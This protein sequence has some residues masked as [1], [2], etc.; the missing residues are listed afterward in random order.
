MSEHHTHRSHRTGWLRAGGFHALYGAK[1]AVADRLIAAGAVA[2][3]CAA[4]SLDRP[5]LLARLLRDNPARA[6]ERGGDG[7]TPLHFARSR[8]IADMLLEA[9]AD[10]DARDVDH[11]ST[12][13]EWMLGAGGGGYESRAELARYLVER[14]AHA[15]IF[16]VA[17][18][19]MPDR[20]RTMLQADPS[21]LALRTSQGEYAEQPPSSYHIYQWTL[22]PNLSPLQ[23]AA[24]YGQAEVLRV[25]KPLASPTEL[26]LL[27]C[28]EGDGA[29]ARAIIAANQ[30]ILGRLNAAERRALTDEAWSAN[31][32]AV[33]LMM[34]LGFDPSVPSTS[35]PRGANALHCSAWEGSVD[36]VSAI[37]RYPAGRALINVREPNYNGT[38]LSWC[39]HGSTN[40]GN[41]N[42][43]HAEVARRLLAAG[44]E[45]SPDMATWNCGGGMQDVLRGW[46]G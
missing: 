41:P 39:C 36:C 22:G 15:D 12:A 30:G 13:A 28:H 7:Q 1:G 17:A 4:A 32:R 42:A 27:A 45:L 19:G 44:A 14:G 6:H 5:E 35:G 43:D 31:A 10:I 9:G 21:L 23:V 3:A 16:L 18:L 11:R 34:E 20:A 40:C 29:E 38:P 24:K 8:T 26:L 37:L 25:M 33:E 2:D 46:V